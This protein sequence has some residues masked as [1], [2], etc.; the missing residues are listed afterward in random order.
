MM[1]TAEHSKIKSHAA[2]EYPHESCGVI[3]KGEG[4]KRCRNIHREPQE[5]FK[6]DPSVIMAYGDRIE[7]VVH[8]HPDGNPFPSEADMRGQIDSNIP[9]GICVV[10]DKQPT[11]PFFFGDGSEKQE[12]IGRFFQHGVS[13]CYSLIRDYYAQ[14]MGTVI[15]EIP[16][17]WEWWDDGQNL[18]NDFLEFAGFEK[19]HVGNIPKKGDVVFFKIRSKVANHAGIYDGGGRILHHLCGR[20]G[21]DISAISNREPLSR[22]MRFIDFW[23]RHRDFK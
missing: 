2:D 11:E 4:Y 16:R 20:S 12:L 10:L 17:N 15:P 8:S 1:F 3:V 13:D 23:A 14:E 9:W 18:Y 6:I 22:W 5:A 7:A 19:T 21:Y